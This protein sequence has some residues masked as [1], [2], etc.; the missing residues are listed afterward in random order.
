MKFLRD[1]LVCGDGP[2]HRDREGC[3]RREATNFIWKA[4]PRRGWHGFSMKRFDI[5]SI[6]GSKSSSGW[7]GLR[8]PWNRSFFIITNCQSVLLTWKF[9]HHSFPYHPHQNLHLH[10]QH[11]CVST[12]C[13]RLQEAPFTQAIRVQCLSEASLRGQRAQWISAC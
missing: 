8:I 13:V 1:C 9:N 4:P 12:H 10:L 6:I 7:E 2:F 3:L 5:L 11:H